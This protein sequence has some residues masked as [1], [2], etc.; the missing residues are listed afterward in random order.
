MLSESSSTPT[1]PQ[2]PVKAPKQSDQ[3]RST[4]LKVCSDG[5]GHA[6]DILTG[7]LYD[8]DNKCPDLWANHI[9]PR[10]EHP[11]MGSWR[12]REKC[13]MLRGCTGI[14]CCRNGFL[15][16]SSFRQ[17]FDAFQFSFDADLRVCVWTDSRLP[18]EIVALATSKSPIALANLQLFPFRDSF[19]LPILLQW[20]HEECQHRFQERIT[21]VESQLQTAPAVATPSLNA[22]PIAISADAS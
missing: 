15:M 22:E 7:K 3:F 13:V 12:D 16:H 17:Y 5:R 18:D 8:Q 20:H 4:L 21:R 9:V 19:C 2:I 11:S 6:V 1:N 10:C 14:D